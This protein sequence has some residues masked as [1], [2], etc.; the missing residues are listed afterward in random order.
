M[1]RRDIDRDE[2][3]IYILNIKE[4]ENAK[5]KKIMI[6][7]AM[8]IGLLMV[9]VNVFAEV[10]PP[11]AGLIEKPDVVI[12]PETGGVYHVP[13]VD[14][15][16]FYDGWWWRLWEGRWY[17]SKS[18]IGEWVGSKAPSFLCLIPDNFRDLDRP[19]PKP[20]FQPYE[21]PSS[22]T[23]VVYMYPEF[24]E[25]WYPTRHRVPYFGAYNRYLYLYR[26]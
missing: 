26:R 19:R 22:E 2:V 12:I 4:K 5:M 18:C 17:Q 6:V 25:P 3:G 1:N 21:K 10:I 15:L 14:D 13:G 8:V 23:H 16:F 24:Y 9:S 11:I 7:L 20:G